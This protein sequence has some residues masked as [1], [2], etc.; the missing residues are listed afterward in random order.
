MANDN[1][2]GTYQDAAGNAVKGTPVT[3]AYGNKM[4]DGK[5]VYPINQPP[6]RN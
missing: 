4:I 2:T 1:Q 5:V 6:K 3:D